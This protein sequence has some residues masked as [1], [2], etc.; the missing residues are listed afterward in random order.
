MKLKITSGVLEA[1]IIEGSLDINDIKNMLK[2]LGQAEAEETI[3]SVRE[4]GEKT[5]KVS[6]HSSKSDMQDKLRAKPKMPI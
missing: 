1:E 5:A 3:T 2:K 4:A 6:P